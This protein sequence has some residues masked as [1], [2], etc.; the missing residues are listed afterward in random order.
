VSANLNLRRVAEHPVAAI[1]RERASSFE[2]AS[3][4][5][6]LLAT[7]VVMPD[8]PAGLVVRQ[9]LFELLRVGMQRRLTLLAAPAGFGKTVLLASW[10]ATVHPAGRVAWVSLD[11]DDNDAGRFWS[12]VLAAL[13]RSGAIA[14]DRAPE[15][16]VAPARG[17]RQVQLAPLVNSLAGLEVPAVLVLDDFHEISDPAILRSLEL[18]LRHAPPQLRLVIATR[19]DPQLPVHRL[20]TSGVLTE[21]RAAE[22]AFTPDEAAELLTSEGLKLT[23]DELVRLHARAEGWAAGLRLAALTLRQ[24]PDPGRLI[25]RFAGDDRSVASYFIGE[26]LDR[27]SPEVR[28]VLLRTAVLDR[29]TGRL[30]DA[31]TGRNDGERVLAELERSNAFVASLGQRGWY[32]YHQLFAELLRAELRYQMPEEVPELHRR[33]A[34]WFAANG[35]A[36]EAARHAIAACDWQ[37]AT[38]VLLGR[39][40]DLVRDDPFVLRE[41]LALLPPEMVRTDPEVALVAAV[42]QASG[43]RPGDPSTDEGRR[44]VPLLLAA[45]QLGEA[46]QANDVAEISV[47]ALKMLALLGDAG[48]VARKD[49]DV[50]VFAMCALVAAQQCSGDLEAAGATLHE[51]LAAAKRAGLERSRLD[52]VSQLALLEADCGRLRAAFRAAHQALELAE[53]HDWSDT[54]QAARAHLALTMVHGHRNELDIAKDHLDR[55]IAISSN[56]ASPVLMD[57]VSIVHAWLNLVRGNIAAGWTLVAGIRRHLACWR[58]PAFTER[59]LTVIEAGLHTATGDLLAARVLLAGADESSP[60][61]AEVAVGL[62]AVELADGE[63]AAAAATLAPYLNGQ[64]SMRSLG[65]LISACLLDAL[66]ARALDDD[67]RAS[68]SLERALVLAGQEGFRLPFIALGDGVPALLVAELDRDTRHRLLVAELLET[69]EVPPGATPPDPARDP[70][71]LV[72]PL[73]ERERVVLRYLGGVLS[74]VEIAS[75]LCVSVNTVKTHVKGI[76][77]K[78]G[79]SGRRQAIRRGRELHL[80]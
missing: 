21:I 66:A 58:A 80:F 64:A 15:M 25:A 5:L 44:S 1:H 12:Y 47:A 53:L 9:R 14:A 72:E 24:Q 70:L 30:V 73:S 8:L 19:A 78:L 65:L 38:T 16:L 75:E 51:A 39:W 59:S 42:D 18:L 17:P 31:L 55:V 46:W 49:D 61:A 3:P 62:A 4:P 33:A 10:I 68:Q 27:Q 22:L 48:Q 79:V 28:A 63:P 60:P 57:G 7:K 67:D 32:R 69:L 71:V 11:A 26:V 41:L 45:F 29:L 43:E 50:R 23:R 77:R 2:R 74:N 34:A 6:S 56:A 52:C 40:N 13:E 54:P 76:Y 20:R 37:L 35:F 36:V